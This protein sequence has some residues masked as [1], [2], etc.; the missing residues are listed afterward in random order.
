M[1]AAILKNPVLYRFV[2]VIGIASVVVITG[3]GSNDASVGAGVTAS[4]FADQTQATATST[5]AAPPTATS[6]G[7]HPRSDTNVYQAPTPNWS[8][9][10]GASVVIDKVYYAS[11]GELAWASNAIVIGSVVEAR[12]PQY[13]ESR[14][15]NR[16][17]D[18]P[19]A[20]PARIFT[21]YVVAV[22]RVLR[23]NALGEVVIRQQGGSIQ[24]V[25]VAN[26]SDPEM[27]IGRQGLFFLQPF[28]PFRSSIS[29]PSSVAYVTAAAWWVD[30]QDI[31]PAL[32]T[33]SDE[34]PP[35]TPLNTMVRDVAAAL[36]GQPLGADA[37]PLS[38]A[39]LG[40]DLP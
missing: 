2:L 27:E 28:E 14:D 20:D 26:M 32:P 7:S 19:Q 35:A 37:V 13:I 30:G 23:G 10:V 5:A 21:D 16:P 38:E 17:S 9:P 36:R 15:P 18:V 12:A 29:D 3:C 6:P 8:T 34:S 33:A 39:P 4:E 11:A 40:P 31:V 24:N 25:T 1:L 22:D